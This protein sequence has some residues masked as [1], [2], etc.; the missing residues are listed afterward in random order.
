MMLEIISVFV[1]TLILFIV[2]ILL[3][4]FLTSRIKNI[5]LFL[6]LL[7]ILT[8]VC[9]LFNFFNSVGLVIFFVNLPVE[10][11]SS[12]INSFIEIFIT[13]SSFVM[14]AILFISSIRDLKKEDKKI[15]EHELSFNRMQITDAG[16]VDTSN[17]KKKIRI[18]FVEPNTVLTSKYYIKITQ[19][20]IYLCMCPDVFNSILEQRYRE[21]SKRSDKAWI[22]REIISDVNKISDI[23]AKVKNGELNFSF[24]IESELTTI[25]EILDLDKMFCDDTDT[26]IVDFDYLI[27]K[28]K[29]L[30]HSKKLTAYKDNTVKSKSFL[31]IF[32]RNKK[33]SME[34][35]VLK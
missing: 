21:I 9:C 22:L 12:P 16:I 17:S 7:V 4:R 11:T 19:I 23:E 6:I 33:N 31:C 27:V 8:S 32:Q 13:I 18:L 25:Q 20:N 24:S 5:A 14:D 3:K 34:T 15:S 10:S 30:K 28:K 35:F 29:S 2:G 1:F 26:L